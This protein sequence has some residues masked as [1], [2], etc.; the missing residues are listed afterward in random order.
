MNPFYR[1]YADFLGRYFGGKVQKISVDAAL[2][3]PNRDGT[4]GRGGCI[5]CNNAAFSP[6]FNKRH[7]PVEEQ[8]E[9]G[10]RFFARKY[11][12]MSYLAY[13]QSYTG[14]H[15]A[16]ENLVDMYS[17]ALRCRDVCGLVIGTRPDC[18]PDMLLQALADLRSTSGKHIFIEYGAETAHDSTLSVINR[19]HTWSCTVDAVRRTASAG[20]PVGVHLIL[21]LPGESIDMMLETVD[22]INGLPVD[23]V[24][25]HQLQVLVGTCLA[26][27]I[28][29]G[30]YSDRIEFTP[31]SYADLCCMI[32][33]RLRPDIAI[34]RFVAQAPSDLLVS[35][36]WGLKNYQFVNLLFKKLSADAAPVGGALGNRP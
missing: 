34:E 3:C 11:P 13:F 7:L 10:K 6:D 9:A 20:F 24:K 27:G 4:V 33:R 1:D 22:M 14:S 26:A 19:C 28:E 36:R 18:M 23:T 12:Q 5:Y 15:G 17:R 35:P 2:G 8:I 30:L 25:F 16:I 29:K 32:V 21:G 31:E